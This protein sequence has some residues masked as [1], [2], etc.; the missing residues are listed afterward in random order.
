MNLFRI[1]PVIAA[2][3]VAAPAIAHPKLVTSSPAANATTG[4][5]STITLNYS[6]KLVPALSGAELIM[7]G[8]PGMADHPPMPITGLKTSVKGGKTLV[9]T[10][11]R[12]LSA[13]TYKLNWHA[14]AADTHRIKGTFAF[15]VK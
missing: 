14:V 6:E 13:G 9:V 4:K 8:M 2:L 12:P 5:I 11:P 7:T 15:R 10:L 1:V 3:A